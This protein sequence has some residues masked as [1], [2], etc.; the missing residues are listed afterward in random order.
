MANGMAPNWN[1]LTDEALG[2]WELSANVMIHSGFPATMT[3]TGGNSGLNAAADNSN[4]NYAGRLNQYFPLKIVGRNSR[5]WWGT[6]PSSLPAGPATSSTVTVWLAPTA[7]RRGTAILETPQTTQ[8]A[9][10]D[11]ETSIC[12]S[13]KG[14]GLLGI[15]PLSFASMPTMYSIW[16]ATQLPIHGQ[17]AANMANYLLSEQSTTAPDFGGL[18]VLVPAR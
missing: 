13:L 14:S 8:N 6:D 2:G 4:Y 10:Q 1:R 11:S 18:H 16:P 3:Y 12:R 7:N 9:I 17:A 15:R 5:H